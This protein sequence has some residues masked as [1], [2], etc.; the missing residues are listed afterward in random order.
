MSMIYKIHEIRTDLIN[1]FFFIFI[2]ISHTFLIFLKLTIS[3]LYF[4]WLNSSKVT[5]SFIS[6]IYGTIS[7]FIIL[8]L[9]IMLLNNFVK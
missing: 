1:D 2:I 4:L 6:A 5:Y 7:T 8:N 9:K 3:N